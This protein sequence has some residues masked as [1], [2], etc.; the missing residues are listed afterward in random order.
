GPAGLLGLTYQPQ[1][2]TSLPSSL[3]V[4][5]DSKL[6]LEN[7]MTWTP[8]LRAAWVHE[9]IPDRHITASFVVAPGFLFNTVGTSAL[10]DSAQI[11]VGSELAV[12]SKVS[13]F[14]SLAT[15]VASQSLAYSGMAGMKV[16]W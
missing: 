14:S 13:L 10:A 6:T 12:D 5:F 16:A 1:S 15:Q 11:V 2:T 8:Y 7:G 9:F 4:Q 3:G